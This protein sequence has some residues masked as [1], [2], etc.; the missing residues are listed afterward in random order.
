MLPITTV[1][2][3][4]AVCTVIGAVA[5]YLVAQAVSES[6]KKRKRRTRA[7]STSENAFTEEES[8]YKVP[9][10]QKGEQKKSLLSRIG[11]M[12]IVLLICAA[13]LI[14]FTL[15]MIDLFKQY[16]MTPDVLITCV[17]GAITGECGFMGW[18]KTNKEKYRD[19][20]WQKEDMREA[21]MAAQVPAV[22][23][24]DMGTPKE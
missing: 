22:D 16:G 3:I 7:R 15:E 2:V 5:L 14:A 20:K 1:I 18:I 4:C 21:N 12:N 24:S 9:S 13:A 17:F 10:S 8:S 23:P 19:R 6:K 11:V